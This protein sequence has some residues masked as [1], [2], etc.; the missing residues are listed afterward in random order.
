M[1]S[2]QVIV[3][4][5]T[6]EKIVFVNGLPLAGEYDIDFGELVNSLFADGEHKIFTCECGIPE[7]AGI[8]DNCVVAIKDDVV[9]WKVPVPLN[10]AAA[11]EKQ[12]MDFFEF[13]R[14]QYEREIIEAHSKLLRTF[15]SNPRSYDEMFFSTEMLRDMSDQLARVKAKYDDSK[16]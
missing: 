6:A 13:D 12:K 15:E 8:W 16:G 3:E 10:N 2:F 1:D 9:R 7:C 5:G 4:E 11:F 14:S